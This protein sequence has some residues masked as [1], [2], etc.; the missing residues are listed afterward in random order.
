[1]EKALLEAYTLI[2]TQ[3]NKTPCMLSPLKNIFGDYGTSDGSNKITHGDTSVLDE[4]LNGV[5]ESTIE[6]L[7]YLT[8]KEDGTKH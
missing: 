8:L 3:A 6:V 1:M 4:G 5:D 7:K 2:L